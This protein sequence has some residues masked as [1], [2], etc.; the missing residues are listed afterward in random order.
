MA[1]LPMPSLIAYASAETGCEAT[2]RPSAAATAPGLS[3]SLNSISGEPIPELGIGSPDHRAGFFRRAYSQGA[4]LIIRAAQQ[5]GSSTGQWF[6][7][8]AVEAAGHGSLVVGATA[9]TSSHS[10]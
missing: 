7:L 10:V 1:A 2:G 3:L 9:E 6:A 5:K 4:L 8:A